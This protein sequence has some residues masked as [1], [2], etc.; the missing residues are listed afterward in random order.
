[1]QDR[2]IKIV[3]LLTKS[4]IGGAQK[5]VADLAANLPKDKY[6][7]FVWHG[8]QEIKHLSNKLQPYFLFLN[9]WLALIE[10][11]FKFKTLKPD[12]VHL[13][14]SKAG[15]LGALAAKLADVKRVIFTAHGWVFQPQ[16]KLNII[17][18]YFY[19]R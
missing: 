12:I 16:N 3:Y 19:I 8:G 9:D 4:D 14:S 15:I 10:L 5:Y 1:M 2:K 18:R 6:E 13:N 11:F 17:I 7:V